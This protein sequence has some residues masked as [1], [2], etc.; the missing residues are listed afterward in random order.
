MA[1]A[2]PRTEGATIDFDTIVRGGSEEDE[3][4]MAQARGYSHRLGTTLASSS[5]GHAFLNGKHF[6]MDDVSKGR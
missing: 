4:R 2:M 1:Q 3:I 5:L 6:V